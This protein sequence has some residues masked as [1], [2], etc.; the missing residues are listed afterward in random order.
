MWGK[1]ITSPGS[2]RFDAA[3]FMIGYDVSICA[4]CTAD[5]VG[6][7]IRTQLLP[8]GQIAAG[9]ADAAGLQPLRSRA[10]GRAIICP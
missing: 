5:F 9:A 4:V 2:L 8:S 10:S 6:L 7:T 1:A 3:T